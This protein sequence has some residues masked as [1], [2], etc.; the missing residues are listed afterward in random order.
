MQKWRP[1]FTSSS[2]PKLIRQV[3]II[4]K[5]F[6]ALAPFLPLS[7]EGLSY[8]RQIVEIWMLE[9]PALYRKF[10]TYISRNETMWP[11]SRFLHSCTLSVSDLH[12]PMI[13]LIWNLYF[14]VLHERTLGSTAGVVRRTGNC[15]RLVVGSSSLPSPPLLPG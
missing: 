7:V 1:D 3:L 13:S 4:F 11:H 5:F 10:E 14:P 9:Y 2:M 8:L 6:F 15:L 12:I